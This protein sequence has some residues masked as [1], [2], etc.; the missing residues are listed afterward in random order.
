[1]TDRD[2]T[3]P[4]ESLVASVVAGNRDV[5]GSLVKRHQDSTLR[6]CIKILS[7]REDAEDALQEA[8]LT[9]FLELGNLR[10]PA[11]FGAWFHAIAA[12]SAR[13]KRRGRRTRL[14][15]SLDESNGKLYL[16]RD[17]NPLPEETYLAR[18]LHDTVMAALE[19]LSDVNREAIV[20]Y[21]LEGYSQAEL[22]QILNVPVSTIKGR[23][24]KGRARLA[25]SLAGP[26]GRPGK[27]SKPRKEFVMDN[28]LVEMVIESGITDPR[29]DANL[30]KW[31]VEGSDRMGLLILQEANGGRILP[32]FML[33]E[34]VGSINLSRS[35]RERPRPMSHDLM[36]SLLKAAKVQVERIII[37]KVV[38]SVYYAEVEILVN[39]SGQTVDA[40]PSDAIAL[41]ARANSPIYAMRVLLEN[42]QFESK[43]KFLSS[44]R[45]NE[46]STHQG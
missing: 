6:L 39:G 5:F 24:F 23:L 29:T 20:A 44:L 14:L 36:L 16:C 26:D 31:S 41:A 18:E 38:E 4:D 9:A 2:A 7:N 33:L 37:N 30:T 40:R 17:S 46:E 8:T 11:R 13:M 27:A 15:D 19:Q 25:G 1:M 21:Y 10:D 45:S 32:I 22:A 43:E 12:N 3:L 34:Q 35:G 42:E 28:Q